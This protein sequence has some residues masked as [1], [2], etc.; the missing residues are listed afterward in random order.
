MRVAGRSSARQAENDSRSGG[1]EGEAPLE[2]SAA[3]QSVVAYDVLSCGTV[4]IRA[5]WLALRCLGV[6]QQAK[7]LAGVEGRDGPLLRGLMAMVS[8]MAM[9]DLWEE[10]ESLQLLEINL[11]GEHQEDQRTQANRRSEPQGQDGGW[12]GQTLSSVPKGNRF[13]TNRAGWNP[14]QDVYRNKGQ[15]G[16]PKKDEQGHACHTSGEC[17][18]VT[19]GAGTK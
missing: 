13:H 19:A 12:Q 4:C 2:V 17:G 8:V 9:D 16:L 5:G 11:R 7:T 3:Q 6:W 10:D 1:E 18:S 14:P 15:H